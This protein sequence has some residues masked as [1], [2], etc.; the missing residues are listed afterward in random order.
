MAKKKQQPPVFADAQAMALLHPTTFEAPDR[1]DL[2]AI[3]PGYYI[4]VCA[5]ERFWVKV[6][7][8]DTTG[9][10]LAFA[11]VVDNDLICTDSHGLSLGS[12]VRVSYRHV[13]ATM[14]GA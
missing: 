7:E 9:D 13:Y 14:K 11:G 4:K 2:A 3:K 1:A 8:V 6:T 5:G 10:D 12:V